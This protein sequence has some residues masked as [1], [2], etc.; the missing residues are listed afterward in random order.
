M[1]SS[2][3]KINVIILDL[4]FGI[5]RTN[6][7]TYNYTDSALAKEKITPKL[8]IKRLGCNWPI[9]TDVKQS[10]LKLLDICVK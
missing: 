9:N 6:A 8:W 2:S 7:Q 3:T 10:S 5:L 4:D 1:K